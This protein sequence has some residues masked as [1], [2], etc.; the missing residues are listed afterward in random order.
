LT[1]NFKREPRPVYWWLG[2]WA[3]CQSVEQTVMGDLKDPRL[4]YIKAALFFVIG[5]LSIVGLLL[6]Y[7]SLRHALL[8]CLAVWAFC[9]LYYFCFYVI[10]KYIDPGYKFA[11]L[12][13]VAIYLWRRRRSN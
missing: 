10:E 8:I 2:V 5:V 12:G 13:S 1:G 3:A 11:G 9:R 7:F 4:M 6:E